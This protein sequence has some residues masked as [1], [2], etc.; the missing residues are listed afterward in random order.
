MK[1][2]TIKSEI[3]DNE[4]SCYGDDENYDLVSETFRDLPFSYVWKMI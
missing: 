3:Y 2:K 4:W 1:F